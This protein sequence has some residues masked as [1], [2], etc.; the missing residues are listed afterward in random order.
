MFQRHLI[1]MCI[2][3]MQNF[4]IETSTHVYKEILP[5]LNHIYSFFEILINKLIKKSMKINI[6]G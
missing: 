4:V 6:H 3:T 2:S 5:I 1:D